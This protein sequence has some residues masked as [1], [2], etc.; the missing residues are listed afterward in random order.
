MTK[1]VTGKQAAAR[2]LLIRRENV[3]RHNENSARINLRTS[4]I[5]KQKVQTM[6]MELDRFHEAAV[7]GS[8]LDAVRIN[9]MNTLKQI[10]GKYK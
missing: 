3:K 7:R 4:Q 2:M 10:I 6:Q 9:R 5:Q 1:I 8:G